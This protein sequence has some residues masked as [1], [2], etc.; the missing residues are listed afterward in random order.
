MGEVPAAWQGRRLL[1]VLVREGPA[2]PRPSWGGGRDAAPVFANAG[3]AVFRLEP[4]RS[5]V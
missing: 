4:A 1:V 2:A 5:R 3:F